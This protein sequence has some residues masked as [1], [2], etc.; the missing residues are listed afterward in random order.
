MAIDSSINVITQL[1]RFWL[2]IFRRLVSK[3]LEKK[4]ILLFDLRFL[5]ARFLRS[6]S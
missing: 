1:I 4:W 5:N 6:L 2:S 3:S